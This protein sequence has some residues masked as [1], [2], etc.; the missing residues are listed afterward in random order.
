MAWAIIK[1]NMS[2]YKYIGVLKDE[3]SFDYEVG[4]STTTNLKKIKKWKSEI[5]ECTDVVDCK[6][7]RIK[8]IF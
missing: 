2:K 6:I 3:H 1:R 8:E 7:L 4:Y 5:L